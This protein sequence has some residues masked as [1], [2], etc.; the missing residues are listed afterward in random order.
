MQAL[1]DVLQIGRAERIRVVEGLDRIMLVCGSEI[2]G[3]C[4][5]LDPERVVYTRPLP[6]STP[7]AFKPVAYLGNHLD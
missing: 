1:L 4:Y 2:L 7:A 6:T 3:G 5:E